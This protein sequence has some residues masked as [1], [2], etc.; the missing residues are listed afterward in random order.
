MA[1][2]GRF[3]KAVQE[4]QDRNYR[5][6]QEAIECMTEKGSRLHQ[7]EV[8]EWSLRRNIWKSVLQYV[9][10][11]ENKISGVENERSHEREKAEAETAE[12]FGHC[13]CRC[14]QSGGVW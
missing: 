12:G 9:M 10:V 3:F 2:I 4:N 1:E 7:A 11:L 6:L 5:E 14:G 13:T 8:D